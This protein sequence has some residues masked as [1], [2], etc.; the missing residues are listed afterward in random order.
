MTHEFCD[1]CP[2]C[3]PALLDLRTGGLMS[4][5]SPVMV[6]MNH[7]WNHETTYAERKAFIDVTVHNRHSDQ[8]MRLAQSIMDKLS[9]GPQ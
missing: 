7:I 8:N 9:L 5:D 3:R 6:R 4:S 2:L 1:H